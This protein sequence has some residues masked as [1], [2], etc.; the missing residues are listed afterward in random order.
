MT[1]FPE[2]DS[3]EL[4]GHSAVRLFPAEAAQAQLDA[5]N[6]RDLDAFVAAYDPA[7][8][9]AR[10]P[11]GLP[12]VKGRAELRTRYGD[13]FSRAPALHCDLRHR[14]VHDRF[15]VDHEEVRGIPGRGRIFAVA[16]YEVVDG[17]I[18]RGWF[19]GE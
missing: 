6:S 15:V 9:L 2:G 5:Y 8:V 18:L 19:L 10:L 4:Q 14:I 17:V 1:P 12:F 11:S 16:I 7:V 3:N 13:L